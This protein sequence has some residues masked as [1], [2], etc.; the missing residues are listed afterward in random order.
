MD[1]RLS[2]R[3]SSGEYEKW[4]S[5]RLAATLGAVEAVLALAV[6]EVAMVA[7]AFALLV[8]AAVELVCAEK[9]ELPDGLEGD[10]SVSMSCC[11]CCRSRS[12]ALVCSAVGDPGSQAPR[13]CSGDDDDD[14]VVS[15]AVLSLI[16]GL[17][18]LATLLRFRFGLAGFLLILEVAIVYSRVRDKFLTVSEM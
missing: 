2:T 8:V 7:F 14:E 12:A 17:V 10:V 4:Q 15:R 9:V 18:V 13:E 11:C 1:T 3:L 5:W 16:A 6:A